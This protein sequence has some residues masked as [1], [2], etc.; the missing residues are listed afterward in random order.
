MSKTRIW[1]ILIGLFSFFLFSCVPTTTGMSEE[2]P[3]VN[4]TVEISET[5]LAGS[6]GKILIILGNQ[7]ISEIYTTIRPKFE[8]EGYVVEV[9]SREMNELF[10]KDGS[11]S[12]VPDLLLA[13]VDVEQYA[14][15]VFNCDND[16]AFGSAQEETNRIIHETLDQEI[17]VA[18]ICAAPRVLGYAD[19][20]KGVTLTAEPSATCN[21]LQNEYGAI[22]TG[23]TVEQDGL[24]ITAKDK[25]ARALFA[26]KIIEALKSQ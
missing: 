14:A 16:I 15:V 4:S 25:F 5:D 2:N 20:V 3:T 10:S 23:N 9:A 7:F 6:S 22:C 19:V 13:D 17:I 11:M 1:I 12:L 18:A 21:L 8:Q 24:I 26:N